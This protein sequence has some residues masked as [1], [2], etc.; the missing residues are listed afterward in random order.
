MLI[1]DDLKKAVPPGLLFGHA[2]HADER[3]GQPG[4]LEVENLDGHDTDDRTSTPVVVN[5]FSTAPPPP[6]PSTTDVDFAFRLG[7]TDVSLNPGVALDKIN[8]SV[9]FTAQRPGRAD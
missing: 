6:P 5:P 2:I 4:F 8:G 1:D 3:N 7:A 9:D